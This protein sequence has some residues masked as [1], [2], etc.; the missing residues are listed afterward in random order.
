MVSHL[1]RYLQD[2]DEEEPVDPERDSSLD[3]ELLE[4]GGW[5][6]AEDTDVVPGEAEGDVEPGDE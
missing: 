6:S 5:D 2:A 3:R 1:Q 4:I